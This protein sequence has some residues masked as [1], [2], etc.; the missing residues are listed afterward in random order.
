MLSGAFYLD[1]K[2][3]FDAVECIKMS[4]FYVEGDTNGTLYVLKLSPSSLQLNLVHVDVVIDRKT[5][6]VGNQWQWIRCG[7]TVRWISLLEGSR[8]Y[9]K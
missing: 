5:G 1:L 3:E 4:P 6:N 7:V 8:V 2:S 9:T